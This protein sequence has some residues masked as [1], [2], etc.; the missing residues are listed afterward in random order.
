MLNEGQRGNWKHKVD[1]IGGVWG[2]TTLT[3]S[4]ERADHQALELRESFAILAIAWMCD[5][6]RFISQ[7]GGI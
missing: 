3:S 7:W 2:R 4:A 1:S 5:A 6:G